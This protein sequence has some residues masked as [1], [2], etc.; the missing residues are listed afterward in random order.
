MA[1]RLLLVLRCRLR[2]GVAPRCATLVRCF[3]GSIRTTTRTMTAQDDEMQWLEVV[4]QDEHGNTCS[5]VA[6][7]QLP[8][9]CSFSPASAMELIQ[10]N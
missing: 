1:S 10:P 9:T 4:A 3:L 7:R 2:G 8:V 5:R 6:M